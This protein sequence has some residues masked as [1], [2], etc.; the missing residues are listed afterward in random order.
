MN[1]V[2]SKRNLPLWLW[3]QVERLKFKFW[4]KHLKNLLALPFTKH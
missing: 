2:K 4:W 3:F 1:L